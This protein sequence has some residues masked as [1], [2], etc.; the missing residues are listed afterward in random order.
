[1]RIEHVPNVKGLRR[2][3]RA[4]QIIATA[5][6]TA[7]VAMAA[8]AIV[9]MLTAQPAPPVPATPPAAAPAA[10][11]AAPSV[12]AAREAEDAAICDA[13]VAAAQALGVL[14]GFA[15]RDGG[16]TR[17]GDRQGRYICGARTD[18]ARYAIVFDLTCTRLGTPGCIVPIEVDL[19]GSPVYRRK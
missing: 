10:P 19:D 15:Q 1:M 14:P 16:H 2:D 3:W 4:A 17:P 11:S 6:G 5:G 12:A 18:A 8:L 7:I 9:G 13:A